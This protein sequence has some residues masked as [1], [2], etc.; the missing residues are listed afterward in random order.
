MMQVLDYKPLSEVCDVIDPHPSHRAPK[1]QA[2]GIPFLG[3]GDFQPNGEISLKKARLVK[4]KIFE[5]HRK[6]YS[7]ND[8][9]LLFGRV[10]S[11]GK[12]IELQKAEFKFAISP[13]LAVL[14]PFGIQ[15]AYLKY[16]LQSQGFMK[17]MEAMSTGSTR[18]SVGIQNLRKAKVP[19]VSDKQQ[20]KIV[21][22]LDQAF[23]E[24]DQA[25]ANAEQNLNNA[26]ELFDSYLNQ[27]FSQR[28]EG[29][30]E[31][32]LGDVCETS[33]GGTPLKS[34]KEFYEGGDIPWL[35][36]GEVGK[37]KYVLQSKNFITRD[38]LE[39]SSAKLFPIDTVLVAMYGATAGEVGIAKIEA[40]TNQAVCGILPNHKVIPEFLYFYFLHYKK[41]LV[42][43]A[44]G[45]AQP[46]I[47]QAK[48]RNTYIPIP[49]V[50]VQEEVITKLN[51]LNNETNQINELSIKKLVLFDELKKS[52][53][54][55][56]FSGELT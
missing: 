36:S 16:A 55:K 32:K 25:R 8:E 13:T 14:K 41:E 11:I 6:R 33:S 3:I 34:R 54:Q 43:Q 7:F 21:A 56:A 23:A 17:Q 52:I 39:G 5:E 2:K 26:R 1:P 45:N 49:P 15:R 37:K 12:V 35:L 53:L 38:G 27:V 19:I 30:E 4:E 9:L 46:N 22:I 31:K 40:S 24:I 48:I 51:L 50:A 29:W 42:A 18:K 20:K 44:V 47:S 28:G 10:A